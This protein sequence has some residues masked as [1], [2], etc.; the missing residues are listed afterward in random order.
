M[1][2]A[3][4]LRKSY[5]RKEVLRGV[6]FTAEPGR[7]TLLVGSNGAGKSTTLKVLTGLVRANGGE[8]HIAGKS[9]VREKVAAQRELSFLPQAPNFHP[10]FTCAQIMDFYGRLRGISRARQAAALE[11]AGLSAVANDRTHTLSGG[12]RQRLGLA[13][14]LLPDAPVLLLDEPGISLDPA[15]RSRLQAL[16]HEEARRGK[17][18]LITTHLISEWNDVA[19]RCLLCRDGVI[20]RELDPTNLLQDFNGSA[21]EEKLA[22][23]KNDTDASLTPSA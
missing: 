10:R 6:S 16:L 23:L 20:D 13:L 11:L 12:M 1:I 15:W 8:A 9:I 3:K 7:I 5:R 18:I 22:F 4:E 21:D 2:V 17:T 14:L 19:H